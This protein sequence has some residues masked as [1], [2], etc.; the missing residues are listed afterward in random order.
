MTRQL[1]TGVRLLR[2][3]KIWRSDQ[4]WHALWKLFICAWKHVTGHSEYRKQYQSLCEKICQGQLKKRH[5]RFWQEKSFHM[6]AADWTARW[7][8]SRRSDRNKNILLK[9][10]LYETAQI[11][12]FQY[13]ADQS[14][15]LRILEGLEPSAWQLSEYMRFDEQEINF[16]GVQ[17]YTTV[18]D[19][20]PKTKTIVDFWNLSSYGKSFHVFTKT[21]LIS[22]IEL[23]FNV[24]KTA[25][26]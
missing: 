6:L 13:R 25:K 26:Q 10:A 22:L 2:F 17:I 3:H 20:Q 11:L 24:W 8:R 12:C 19:L 15:D 16:R 23:L 4:F 1:L 9:I 14:K 5:L 7:E 21:F 18:R